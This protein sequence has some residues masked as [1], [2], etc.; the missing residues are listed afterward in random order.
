MHRSGTSLVAS[1]LSACGLRLHDGRVIGPSV[2]N[3]RG[4]FEDAE[5]VELDARAI[6]RT[7]P[8]SHGWKVADARPCRMDGAAFAE[9]RELV[10]R[11]SRRLGPW[12]FKDPRATLLLEDWAEA[13]A[14]LA[15]LLLWRPCAEV[16]DSLLRRSAAATDPVLKV[17]PDTACRAWIAYNEAALGFRRLY[18][19]ATLLFPVRSVLAQPEKVLSLLEERFGLGLRPVPLAGIVGEGLGTARAELGAHRERAEALEAELAGISD[20]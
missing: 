6:T 11:R 1:W 3:E 20:L 5:I 9:A 18:P 2:G 19:E 15:V 17:D 4:H 10:R 12:G 7:H 8:A 14:G 13:A 16:V